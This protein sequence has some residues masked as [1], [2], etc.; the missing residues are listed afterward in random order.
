[1]G[2]GLRACLDLRPREQCKWYILHHAA[3]GAL[4]PRVVGG[5]SFPMQRP[6][7]FERQR[8]HFVEGLLG[9]HC[10]AEKSSQSPRDSEGK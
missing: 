3:P 2:D 8:S 5:D 1:M 7:I 9:L 6:G 4:R 10:P